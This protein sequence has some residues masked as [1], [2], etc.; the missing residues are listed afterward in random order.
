M[1]TETS[2]RERFGCD[3]PSYYTGYAP[4][5]TKLITMTIETYND[6]I[7]KAVFYDLYHDRMK[8]T[9]SEIIDPTGRYEGC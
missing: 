6:L 7:R 2:D 5:E 9:S 3:W 1:S 8:D 4:Q